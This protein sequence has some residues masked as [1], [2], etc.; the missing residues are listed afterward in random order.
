MVS[1]RGR[2]RTPVVDRLFEE[3]HA[4]DFFQAVQVLE[5]E[6]RRTS[7]APGGGRVGEDVSPRQE[8]VRFSAYQAL[9]FPTAEA[10][11]AKPQTQADVD[12]PRQPPQ[13]SVGFMGLTGP[14][15]VLPQHYTEI[16]IRSLREKNPAVRDFFDLF[17]H[18]LISLFHRAWEK[19]R[20]PAAYERQAPDEDP[21]TACL[22]AIVGLD[23]PHLRNRMAVDDEAIV[24]FAGHY[25]HWPRSV[26][27][28]ESILSD[29]FERPVRVQQFHG[30]WTWLSADEFTALPTRAMPEG[31]FAQLGMNA[32]VG[33]RV[34]DVQG[35][36]R[37]RIGPVRYRQFIGFMP[38]SKDLAQLV[39]LTRLFVGPTFSFDMQ[40]TLAKE[41]VPHLALASEGEY[42]PRLGWNTWL[43][44]EEFRQDASDAVFLLDRL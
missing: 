24:H 38:G 31:A 8:A 20:L 26:A 18:R 2:S 4:F 28:L 15:G 3:P 1:A 40:L 29:F 7:D 37:I 9:L 14:S 5:R 21:V 32:V 13:L 16:L 42:V 43:K 17:N 25:A 6:A 36:F 19:Y 12:T 35:S 27:A 41:E 23:T 44:H 22:M 33:E 30:R 10:L 11:E 34:W 39:D